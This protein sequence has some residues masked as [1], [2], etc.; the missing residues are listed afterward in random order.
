MKFL[1]TVAPS[2]IPDV[3]LLMVKTA[4]SVFSATASLTTVKVTE[5][6]V[7]PFGMVIV[8]LESV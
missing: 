5:P 3:G 6:E 7:A 4:V 1:E 8:V 2:V